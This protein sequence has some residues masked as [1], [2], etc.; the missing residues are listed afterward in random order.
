MFNEPR[1]PGKRAVI[2]DGHAR[3]GHALAHAARVGR[4]ALAVEI[5]FQAVAHR[6]VQQH[7]RPAGTQHHRH[8]PGGRVHRFQIDQRLAQGLAGELLR[9]AAIEKLG[10]RIAPAETG[11]TRFAAAVLLHD[12]LD[13]HAHQRPYVRGQHA[14]AAR[15]Q[16]RVHATGKADRHLLHARIGRTQQLV[17]DAQRFDLGVVVQRIDRVV[18][19]IQRTAA[20]AHQRVRRMRAAIAGD[21][22]RGAGRAQQRLR[23]DVIGI[24]E[25]GLLAGD[26]A[27]ADALVDGVRA[28]LDDAVLHRPALAPR[29]LEVEIA[30]IDAG[31]KQGAE[32]AMQALLVESGG[33]QEAGFGEGERGIRHG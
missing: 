24:G 2:D 16:H 15:D 25:A 30:E 18:A 23:I 22:A 29:M 8:R 1:R 19:G 28:V 11:V 12:H 3:R 21:R 26:R 4:G 33:K 13:V 14:V 27:H 20:A 32:G 31:P 9:L 7:A 17:D 5:A 6:L 10:I